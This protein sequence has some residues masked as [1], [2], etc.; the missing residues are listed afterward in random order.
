MNSIKFGTDGWRAII[1]E[2]FTFDNVLKLSQA[3]ASYWKI[4]QNSLPL[5]VVIG[6]DRRFLSDRFAL[7]SAEIFAA[8]GFEVVLSNESTPTPAVS[9]SVKRLNCRGGIVFTASHNPPIYNGFK[10]KS[11]YGGPAFEKESSEIEKLLDSSPPTRIDHCVS[12]KNGT[13][14]FTDLKTP[15]L[16]AI[17]KRVDMR[18]ISA[19]KLKIAHDAL[20]GTGA[21]CFDE[22]LKGSNCLVSSLNA[23][24]DPLFGGIRPEPIPENYKATSKWLKTNR[25]NI[26]LVTDG[27]ADRIGALDERGVPLTAH[28]VICLIVHHILKNRGKK[29]KI[30]KS[31][32]TTSMVDK[33]CEEY[34]VEVIETKIG[35]RFLCEKMLNENA[36]LGCEESG[37]V[38]LA[39]F[40]PERDGI[41][42]GMMLIE[43]LATEKTTVSSLLK[44]LFRRYGKHV[45]K[46]LDLTV[47][48]ENA[49]RAVMKLME[50][51]PTKICGKTVVHVNVL[52]GI[53]FI[54]KDGWLMFR[55]SGTEPLLRIYCEAESEKDI[56]K[57]IKY[58][59][60]T[61]RKL[62]K[63]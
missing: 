14:K 5:R 7:A 56:E 44:N 40:V 15:Y 54:F 60:I 32:N 48:V 50:S 27:D 45:N 8:N 51:P 38:G 29:G 33:I 4:S 49:N 47:D 34:G 2:N 55:A 53:K 35:F 52:D 19:A 21:G 3:T 28:Q 18:L 11:F 10:I 37:S 36:F 46:R 57:L 63:T 13:V 30:A 20:H 26:C 9:F 31:I 43:L 23:D 41:L 16:N 62:V 59:Y 25:H 42:A 24:H 61:I 22:L 12:V 6:Y 17:K 1:A 39:D 58:G